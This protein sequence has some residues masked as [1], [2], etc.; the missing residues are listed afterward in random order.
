MALLLLKKRTSLSSILSPHFISR[1]VTFCSK[2][3]TR[4]IDNT[5]VE[6]SG[7]GRQKYC[8]NS[9]SNIHLSPLYSDQRPVL[10]GYEIE[11]V[12][13][14]TWQ[15]KTGLVHAWN[16]LERGKEEVQQHAREAFDENVDNVAPSQG[17]SDFDEIDN[18]RV[19][20]NLFYKLDRDSKEY[21]EYSYDFHRRKSSKR[22]VKKDGDRK[23][24]KKKEN[25]V[26]KLPPIVRNEKVYSFHPQKME[27]Y[28]EADKKKVRKPTYNQLTGPYHEPFC[29]DLYISKASVR[30]CIIHRVTSKVVAVAHSISKDIKFDLTSTR[31]STACTAVGS[32]LAQRALEDDIHDVIYTPRKGERIEGKL[33]IVLQSIIDNGINVKVKLK[34]RNPK[35][36]RF[37]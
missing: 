15:V 6:T 24:N 35:K 30:A 26:E 29:L 25:K 2:T 3:S 21:E 8:G 16:G 10:D 20:G 1:V 34:Q 22:N 14:E 23:E 27:G 5:T 28:D 11:V 12:D 17:D 32:I 13:D 9:V 33:Q 7:H 4:I 19:R 37:P 36:A 18:M 31:N